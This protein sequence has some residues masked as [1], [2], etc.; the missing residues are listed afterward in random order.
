MGKLIQRPRTFLALTA[1]GI[2]AYWL[3]PNW[4]A[5]DPVSVESGRMIRG[6]T[7]SCQTWG[8]EWADPA[9][10]RTIDD[11]QTLG[12]N[13]IAFHPYAQ[14]AAD[15][16]IRW[17]EMDRPA[18][19][20]APQAW[21]KERGMSVMIVPHLAYWG[22]PFSWRGDIRFDSE[23]QWDVFF[24]DYERWI[25]SIARMAE[26]G[27]A[28]LFCVGLE[29]TH[30]QKYVQKWRK[31]IASVRRVYRGRITYGANW[32]EIEKVPFWDELD[33]VGVLAYFPLSDAPRPSAHELDAGWRRWEKK[34]SR[35]SGRTGKSIL[36]VELG[37]D[38]RDEAAKKPWAFEGPSGPHARQIQTRCLKAAMESCDRSPWLA[39]IFLW[40]WFP[41]IADREEETFD[42][43]AAETRAVIQEA[44]QPTSAKI[45]TSLPRP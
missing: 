10:E 13:G 15:G 39:G 37:Y 34:L 20:M 1:S 33:H 44:W 36:Y 9:M 6:M 21:A 38:Q 11:L 12:V 3:I 29:Y 26:E 4:F 8:R 2:F 7:V 41:D 24:A 16:H 35:L 28:P 31:I 45:S 23:A 19:I 27:G 14:I 32:N 18:H 43:R 30:A 17:R 5:P 25:T 42:L 22:S 40:K